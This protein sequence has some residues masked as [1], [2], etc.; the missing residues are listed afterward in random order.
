MISNALFL[1][2][3]KRNSSKPSIAVFWNRTLA[4]SI[5]P[6]RRTTWSNLSVWWSPIKGQGRYI[7]FGARSPWCSW[8]TIW[9]VRTGNWWSSLKAN[10]TSSSS[11]AS[12]WAPDG[13]QTTSLSALSARSFQC[14]WTWKGR[15]RHCSPT[16]RHKWKSRAVL[17]WTLP[18]SRAIYAIRPM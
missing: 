16:G 5:G 10:W 6:S 3:P 12:I 11:A 2:P 14:S 8:S 9:T 17:S 18:A 1:S 13:W 15:K 7:L 4:R